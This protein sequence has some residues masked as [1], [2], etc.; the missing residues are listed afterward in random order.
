MKLDNWPLRLAE[1][2]ES[3]RSK[4]FSYGAFDCG[5]FA[6]DCVIAQTGVDP[7][8]AIRGY[9]NKH[10]AL[11]II[12]E[13]GGVLAMCTALLGKEPI[14]PSQAHR[15]DVVAAIIDAGE[16]PG[17]ESIGICDG[18][19]AWFPSQSGVTSRPTLSAIAAWRI[20]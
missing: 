9:T 4:L 18:A 14:H 7:A 16:D 12:A 3:A 13:H 6:A 1:A 5:L 15:G 8:A 20:A 19:R 17:M 2:I 11:R 10:A